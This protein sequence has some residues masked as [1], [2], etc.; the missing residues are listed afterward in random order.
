MNHQSTPVFNR[1]KLMSALATIKDP[2]VGL[3]IV[4]MGLLYNARYDGAQ[5]AIEMT[6]TTPYCP[7]APF[8][9][10]EV[11]RIATEATGVTQV[12]V[13][14]VFSPLWNPAMINHGESGPVTNI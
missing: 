9:T 8:F 3:D 1:A 10:Q 2:E 4:S 5:V 11:S 14:F 7:L 12:E 13:Q 6:M